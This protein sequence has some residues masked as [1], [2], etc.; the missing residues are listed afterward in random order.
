[1]INHSHR[2][3]CAHIWMKYAAEISPCQKTCVGLLDF[4]HA[5][6]CHALE[7]VRS[8][9][10]ALLTH[11]TSVQSDSMRHSISVMQFGFFPFLKD[12][13]EVI[14]CLCFTCS[15]PHL[16]AFILIFA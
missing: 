11:S 1:M 8:E 5:T 14:S 13:I 9:H 6:S 15:E 4:S 16:L 7:L 10:C 3:I 2:N 12:M